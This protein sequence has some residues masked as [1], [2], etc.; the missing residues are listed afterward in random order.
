M[1]FLSPA[2]DDE[3]NGHHGTGHNE[4]NVLRFSEMFRVFNKAFVAQIIEDNCRSVVDEVHQHAGPKRIGDI[5]HITQQYA[6]EHARQETVELEVDKRE[7]GCR[8]EDGD[9]R[10]LQA[11]RQ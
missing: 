1:L 11:S 6:E 4:P 9:M 2:P 10:V 8:E 3:R 7:D 5:E